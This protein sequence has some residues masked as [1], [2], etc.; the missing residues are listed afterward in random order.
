MTGRGGSTGSG[1]GA[2]GLGS[3]GPG[4]GGEVPS[5]SNRITGINGAGRV[6]VMRDIY[7]HFAKLGSGMAG[8]P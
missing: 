5:S 6:V 8:L 4:T 2:G 3:T 7:P 1:G